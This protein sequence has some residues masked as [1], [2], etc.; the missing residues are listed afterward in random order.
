MSKI[1][2]RNEE[3]VMKW[4]FIGTFKPPAELSIENGKIFKVEKI[5]P[6]CPDYEFVVKKF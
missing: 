4:D 6:G 2:V 5:F 1:Q 3:V